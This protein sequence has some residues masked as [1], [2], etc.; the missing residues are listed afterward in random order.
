MKPYA[1]RFYK[2][3]Q[4]QRT[5]KA[6]A[7]SVGYLCELCKEKGLLRPGE[8]VHHKI[9]LTEHTIHDPDIALSW[10]NLCLV[11]R[12]CHAEL[13]KKNKKRYKID[14]LGHVIPI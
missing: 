11:C 1:E 2:S 6:Y 13:H 14:E 9:H 4:W 5:S 10:S 3:K 12:D 7:A 8:I